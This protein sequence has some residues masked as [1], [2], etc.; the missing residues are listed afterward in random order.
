VFAAQSSSTTDLTVRMPY[1]PKGPRSDWAWMSDPG[2]RWNP[3]QT[4]GWMLNAP[5]AS[6]ATIDLINDG[7]AQLSAASG[8]TFHYDG[9]TTFVPTLENGFSEPDDIVAAWLPASQTDLFDDAYG[10]DGIGGVNYYY[11]PGVPLQVKTGYAYWDST[12]MAV[13]DAHLQHTLVLHELGHAVSLQHAQYP[14]EVMYPTAMESSP[15]EYSAGD[16]AGLAKV[17]AAAGCIS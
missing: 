6:Q 3:C 17:G 7:F 5:G 15:I 10:A 8:L 12:S 4:I 1:R 13:L 14:T 2:A 16:R 9:A 11:G